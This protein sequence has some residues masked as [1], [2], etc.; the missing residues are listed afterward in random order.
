MIPIVLDVEAS[1]F[2]KG[3]YPIEL[4]IALAD[5]MIKSYLIKPLDNWM[6]WDHQAESIHG[7]PRELL[8]KQGMDIKIV[9][10]DLNEVLEGMVVYSDGWGFDSS[11]LSLLF[12]SAGMKMTFRLDTLARIL[13]EAQMAMWDKVRQEILTEWGVEKH[14][15]PMDA[16]VLQE[17]YVRALKLIS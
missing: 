4:G 10:L 3:S 12:Y 11:W 14:R 8:V 9:C 16:K 7:I 17:T 5:R 13:S 2:G 6:H 15:A 1:G